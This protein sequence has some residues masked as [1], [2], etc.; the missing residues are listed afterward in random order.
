MTQD[1]MISDPDTGVRYGFHDR[2]RAGFP[3]QIIAGITEVCNLACAHCLLQ[4]MINAK[5]AALYY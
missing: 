4:G 2:L 1:T 3:S 5:I